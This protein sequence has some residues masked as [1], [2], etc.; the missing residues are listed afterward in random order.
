MAETVAREFYRAMGSQ[1]QRKHLTTH[2]VAENDMGGGQ[3]LPDILFN[4]VKYNSPGTFQEFVEAL[5][6]MK[7]EVQ[8]LGGVIINPALALEGFSEVDIKKGKAAVVSVTVGGIII[9]ND[10]KDDPHVFSDSL[11]MMPNPEASLN[12]R[13]DKGKREWLVSVYNSR[14]V[15]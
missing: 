12:G 7:Y 4:G 1:P 10:D 8:S 6:K 15:G 9:V 2:F 11:I 3:K 13:R 5:P 14:F